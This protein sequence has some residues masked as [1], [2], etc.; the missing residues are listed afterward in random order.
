MG[1]ALETGLGVLGLG[2]LHAL[3]PAS[4]TARTGLG[5]SGCAGVGSG[6]RWLNHRLRF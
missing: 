5:R 2:G 3:L 6:A 1:Q 4:C